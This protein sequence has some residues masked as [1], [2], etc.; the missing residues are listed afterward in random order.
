MKKSVRRLLSCAMATAMVAGLC[1]T[2][3]AF[4]YP[5]SYWPLQEQWTEATQAQNPDQI[6]SVAQQTYDLLIP[7]GLSQD[8]CWNLEPKCAQASWACE[9]KGDIDGAILWL[10]RQLEMDYWL[11]ENVSSYRDSILDNEARLDYLE[12]ARDVTIYAQSNDDASPYSVGPRTGTW[13]GAPV[14]NPNAAGSAALLYI[15]FDPTYTAQYWVDYHTNNNDRLQDALNGGVIEVAWNFPASTAGCQQVLSSYSYIADSLATFGSLDA[16]ILLRP[17][18]EMNNWEDCDPAVFI[19]AF[20][21][22]AAAAQA[23]PNIQVVFSPD[24]VSNRNHDLAEFY[25][26]DQ[27]VDWV[28]IS[29]YHRTNYAGYNNQPSEYAMGNNTYGSNAYYGQGIYD[30]DP[31]VGIRYIVELAREHNKPV[32]ISECGFSYWNGSQDTTAY[33]VDQLN[34][35]YSYVNMIYPE[36]KAVFYFDVVEEI[37]QYH[38]GLNG[39]SALKSAY[40]NAIAGNGAY[41]EDVNDSA[42]GWENLGQT[43]L[44]EAGVLKLATYASFPG[45]QNATVQYY[46]DGNLA[47]TS[48]QAPYYFELDLAA[49]GGGSHTVYAVASGNQFSRTSPT[50]TVNAPA[51]P[52]VQTPSDWAVGLINEADAAGLVTERTEGVYHDQISRLQFAELAVN[53][54]EQATGEAIPAGEDIFTDTDDVMALKAVAAGVTSGTGDGLFSPDR[55][56]TRQ[57]ICVM[58][59]AV[60]RYVDEANGTSTL[61]NDD[62]T[63]NRELFPDADQIDS[64]AAPSVALLTNNGLMAGKDSGVA[65]HDNTTVE[66][67]IILVLALYNQF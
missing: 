38:Y 53:L 1:M 44:D 3:S 14:D 15:E 65:P 8:V 23:Y 66:E 36:V 5:S 2:A 7:Y 42:T 19:Q 20:Q 21:K 43:Q 47:A 60:I 41:L 10:Q 24:M 25:P 61:E 33:A 48:T 39:S 63:V 46:V 55:K 32:M 9:I 30:Y 40:T 67:A 49:L 11:T 6:I 22:V 51:V 4:T 58:L 56:I 54:I 34:K 45:V 59:N 35:F 17:G 57:E 37:E 16:T 62:T 27:Y 13:Y 64:W 29:V 50:Y 18:A 31:L 26:G 28:G 12:A 52:V